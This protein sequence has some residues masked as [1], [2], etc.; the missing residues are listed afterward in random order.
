MESIRSNGIIKFNENLS[1]LNLES[2]QGGNSETDTYIEIRDNNSLLTLNLENFYTTRYVEG[3]TGALRIRDNLSLKS[4][5]FNTN[6]DLESSIEIYN[7]QSLEEINFT[8]LTNVNSGLIRINDNQNLKKINFN[9]L[10]SS[11]DSKELK[12]ERAR[13]QYI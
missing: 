7:N 2:F 10:I 8:S 4:I 12:L 3:Y 5:N 9:N 1:K 13:N 11:R 6:L